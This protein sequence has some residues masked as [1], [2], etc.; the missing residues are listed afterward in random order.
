MEKF[1]LFGVLILALF[2]TSCHTS[3]KLAS[4]THSPQNESP[5]NQSE[6]VPDP[7][8]TDSFLNNLLAQRPE[9]D[10]IRINRKAWNV[11]IIYTRIDRD[12]RNEPKFT[13]YFWNVDPKRYFYPAS[14]VKMPIAL[15]ALQKLRE[16]RVAGLDRKATMITESGYSG[17]TPVYNDPTTPD[18]KPNIEQ[19]VRKIF[20]VSDND[21]FNRLYEFLGPEAINEKLNKMG[22]TDAQIIH[23]LDISL[24]EDENRHTNPIQFMDASGKIMYQQGE[25]FDEKSY[26]ERHEKLGN[27]FYNAGKL[28]NEPMDFSQKNRISLED[29]HTILKSIY[30]PNAVSPK[31]RF[32]ISPEDF[33]L[34]YK[35][36]SQ[37][38]TESGYPTYDTSFYPAYCKFFL[39]GADPKALPPANLR[40][41]NKVGEAYGSLFDV[42]Y[43]VDFTSKVEFMLSAV[44]YCNSDGILNDDH[45][46][47]NSVGYPFFSNLGKVIYN[48][49][50]QRQRDFSPDLSSMRFD[51]SH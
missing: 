43:I 7:A 33:Q 25:M 46:D 41:F 5:T 28:I 1:C 8:R 29:L 49:E 19:Y 48:Y 35:S 10:S 11:Q 42:A 45:Y 20:L 14:T 34:V 16:L 40:I 31:Q 9:F 3:K 39:W 47:Y 50:L 13:D 4:D 51:Y 30:F 2:S 32:N 15:L 22:Y 6:I 26:P 24:S 44:I 38:P 18:G 21:A 36:M 23:R 17:Q 27:G 37:Y 12:A